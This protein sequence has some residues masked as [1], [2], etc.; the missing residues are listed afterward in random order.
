[1]G[2][3]LGHLPQFNDLSQVT[4]VIEGGSG[5]N[6]HAREVRR[7]G[8][9][10]RATAREFSLRKVSLKTFA[11]DQEL[12]WES[13]VRPFANSWEHA[14][15]SIPWWVST[16]LLSIRHLAKPCPRTSV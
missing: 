4:I 2:Q 1:M 3:V 9:G 15:Q 5:P 11:D 10:L 7:F 16:F 14:L 6:L 12:P 8:E 13:L